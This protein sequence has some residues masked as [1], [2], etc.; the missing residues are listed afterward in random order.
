M[1]Y[2]NTQLLT[3]YFADSLTSTNVI[4]KIFKDACDENKLTDNDLIPLTWDIDNKYFTANISVCCCSHKL[5]GTIKFDEFNGLE[6]VLIIADL[7]D[8]DILL[9]VKNILP[10]IEDIGA[11][12]CLLYS[13][14]DINN[15]DS[16]NDISA[17]CIDNH[18]ELIENNDSS[19]DESVLEEKFGVD[20]VIEA[21]NSHVW[22]SHVMK[23]GQS[24]IA[25]ILPQSMNEDD[26][27]RDG[28]FQELFGKF[29]LMKETAK[30]LGDEERKVYAE[31]V[32]LAF[33]DALGLDEG[34]SD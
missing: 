30:S 10:L 3:L 5:S 25:D 28:S 8:A 19:D 33:M 11:E 22:N 23:S 15:V 27:L 24:Y 1:D 26:E 7:N 13:L 18:F 32:S 17:F 31:K 2:E 20:R 6:A 4:K 29:L 16:K 34:D 9:K 14:E 12:V 21:L